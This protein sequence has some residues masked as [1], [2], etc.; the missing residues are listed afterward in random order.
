MRVR[1]LKPFY[2]AKRK[3]SYKEGDVVD[4]SE[5]DV[6]VWLRHGMAMQDKSLDGG[7]EVKSSAIA[8][9]KSLLPQGEPEP[10]ALAN[11]PKPKTRRKRKSTKKKG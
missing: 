3:T 6:K 7:K 5:A 10:T 2:F 8:E 11:Q 9:V 1:I 4:A